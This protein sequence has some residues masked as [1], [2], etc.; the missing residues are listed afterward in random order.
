[1]KL[2]ADFR[3]R[4]RSLLGLED[5]ILAARG[6]P[7]Q[8]RPSRSSHSP[9][10][11]PSQCRHRASVVLER[12]AALTQILTQRRQGAK[13]SIGFETTPLSPRGRGAGGEGL[14]PVLGSSA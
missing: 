5:L 14:S 3:A 11:D 9:S 7:L 10:V 12:G 4:D 1:M 2:T 13:K 8:K 6:R